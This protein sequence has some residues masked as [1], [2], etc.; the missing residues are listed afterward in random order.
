MSLFKSILAKAICTTD[1]SIE[2]NNA[3]SSWYLQSS[4]VFL[5]SSFV[6]ITKGPYCTTSCSSGSPAIYTSSCI[7]TRNSSEHVND[8]YHDEIGFTLYGGD[9]N[10]CL[11]ATRG[12]DKRVE[13]IMRFGRVA[14]GDLPI[15]GCER[16]LSQSNSRQGR[17]DIL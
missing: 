5:I 11:L 2:Q 12:Q 16:R 15:H 9:G 8:P 10:A 7:S 13:R 14:D 6:V 17:R 3:W 4:S 1:Q